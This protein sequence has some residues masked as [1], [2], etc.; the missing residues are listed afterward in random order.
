ME[1][2]LESLL[3]QI[4]IE[5]ATGLNLLKTS[6][7]SLYLDKF[8]SSFKLSIILMI[9]ISTWTIENSTRT[10]CNSL[11]HFQILIE[12]EFDQDSALSSSVG[13][14]KCHHSVNSVW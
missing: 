2:Q 4:L 8:K 6:V 11:G 3:G 9:G 5:I 13:M 10:I 1:I 14:T 12:T 7:G